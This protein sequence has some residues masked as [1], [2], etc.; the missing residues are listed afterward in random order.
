MYYEEHGRYTD[1]IKALGIE[2]PELLHSR[3]PPI[4]QITESL[5]EVSIEEK[6]HVDHDGRLD[7]WHIRQDSKTRKDRCSKP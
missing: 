4:L 2:K 6:R 7:R 5:F 1:N 3:W